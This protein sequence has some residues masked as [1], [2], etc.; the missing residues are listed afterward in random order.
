MLQF[1]VRRPIVAIVVAT[2]AFTVTHPSG[3]LAGSEIAR[4]AESVAC[5]LV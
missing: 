4:P 5:L 3:E 2:L 1:L